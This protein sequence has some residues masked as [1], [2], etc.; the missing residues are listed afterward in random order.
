M[1]A[2]F[3]T[4]FAS[5]VLASLFIFLFVVYRRD[6]QSSTPE[7]DSL[8]PLEEEQTRPAGRQRETRTTP[9]HGAPEH[10]ADTAA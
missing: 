6:A 8:M 3:L 7:R 4:V 5:V 10:P 2:I 9:R 1:N